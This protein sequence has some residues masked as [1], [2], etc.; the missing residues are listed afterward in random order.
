ML[1]SLKLIVISFM[2]LLSLATPILSSPKPDYDPRLCDPRLESPLYTGFRLRAS[3]PLTLSHSK[4][5]TAYLDRCEDG[6][7]ISTI[8]YNLV[9]DTRQSW[10]PWGQIPYARAICS[11]VTCY[12]IGRS[13]ESVL[14]DQIS[15]PVSSDEFVGGLFHIFEGDGSI[16]E[17]IEPVAPLITEDMTQVFIADFQGLKQVHVPLLYTPEDSS[18]IT[19]VGG[20][21]WSSRVSGNEKYEISEETRRAYLALFEQVLLVLKR[22]LKVYNERIQLLHAKIED[23]KPIRKAMKSVSMRNTAK[24]D[25]IMSLL[26][27]RKI[28]NLSKHRVNSHYLDLETILVMSKVV[29]HEIMKRFRSQID[30]IYNKIPIF[31]SVVPLIDYKTNDIQSLV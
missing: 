3:F 26:L 19:T 21:H 25:A 14:R 24:L 8:P 7:L 9:E 27:Q 4:S 13:R 6:H 20:H 30:Q 18:P 17:M 31:P 10:F 28:E 22:Y 16:D 23:K 29:P 11:G 2:I 1:P 12:K 15:I 5:V